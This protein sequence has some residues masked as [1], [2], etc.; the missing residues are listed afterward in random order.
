[1]MKKLNLNISLLI[2]IMFIAALIRLLPHPP[3]FSPIL[4]IGIFGAA[5]FTKKWHALFIS[6]LAIWFS[7]LIIN[8]LI[9]KTN[10][11]FVWFYNGFLWQYG[12][13]IIIILSNI[14]IFRNKISLAKTLGTAFG[15]SAI[16]FLVSNF[17]VWIGSLMYQKNLIGLL[18]CYTAGIPFFQNTIISN[19]LF[20]IVLFGS[21]YLIQSEY[22]S[23]KNK[24]IQYS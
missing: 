4:A 11:E 9:Y 7:D 17:G 5:H 12:S 20:T 6:L 1:M 23:I 13:Y 15:S 14:Y 3:N 16:F 22:S 21:Y 2:G 19:F 24:Q 8:N 10:T 18:T